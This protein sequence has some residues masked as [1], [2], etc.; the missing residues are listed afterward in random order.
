MTKPAP[1]NPDELKYGHMQIVSELGRKHAPID[2]LQRAEE[3]SLAELIMKVHHDRRV[4]TGW[5]KVKRIPMTWI[6]G[7]L[8]ELTDDLRENYEPV[9]WH[10]HVSVRTLPR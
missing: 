5:P 7:E 1:H 8:R 10:I 9:E 3:Q 2:L 6:M 4:G